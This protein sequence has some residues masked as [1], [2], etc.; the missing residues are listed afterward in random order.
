[1]KK[2]ITNFVKIK[3]VNFCQNLNKRKFKVL[4]F[5]NDEISLP[6]L[7]KLNEDIHK[8]NSAVEKIGI[9]TTPL[10]NKKSTQAVFH[11][12]LSSFTKYELNIK[13]LKQSWIDLM[14]EI[15]KYDIGI[16]ASFGKMVPGSVIKQLP[17]GAYVMHPS[18]LPKYRGAAPIQHALLN[19]EKTTGISIVGASIG[20]FDAGDI[21]L[22]KEVTIEPF[23]RFKELALKLSHLGGDS[24]V[25]FLHDF[26]RFKAEGR[27]QDESMTTDARLISDN[28]FVY[29][30][31][32]NKNAE[33]ILTIFK[34]FY[35]SQL[36]PFTKFELKD[37]ERLIFFDNLFIVTSNSEIYKTVLCNLKITKPGSIIWDIKSHPNNIYIKSTT[38]W[39]MTTNVKLDCMDYQPGE[40]V[41]KKILQSKKFKDKS[42][43]ETFYSTLPKK[44]INI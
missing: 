22:Q 43:E 34:A 37:K 19:K 8:E 20:K 23:H 13:D 36:N 16:I 25:E 6:S 7:V 1:M 32:N 15:E 5:G 40:V 21:Y 26:E 41:I 11:N 12:Y 28:E 10:L 31:F 42:E 3:K 44:L 18:L 38:D 2:L 35:G 30:D 9:I 39:L 29:L 27:K 33:E 17:F 4:F 24:V 14:P